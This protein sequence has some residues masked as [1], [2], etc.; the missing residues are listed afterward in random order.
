MWLQTNALT[1]QEVS[2][3]FSAR[4]L[5]CRGWRE[6]E[7][8][9]LFLCMGDHRGTVTFSFSVSCWVQFSWMSRWSGLLQQQWLYFLSLFCFPAEAHCAFGVCFCRAVLSDSFREWRIKQE[10]WMEWMRERWRNTG[11]V[12]PSTCWPTAWFTFSFLFF[13]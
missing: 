4:F 6:R 9:N 2:A 7:K 10:V 3:R 8:C 1:Q 5:T 11:A 13:F 12:A